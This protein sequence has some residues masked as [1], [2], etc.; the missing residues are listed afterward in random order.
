MSEYLTTMEAAEKLKMSASTLSKLRSAGTG[1]PYTKLNSTVR[2]RVE[3]LDAWAA[4]NLV[5]PPDGGGKGRFGRK[6][7]TGKR[8]EG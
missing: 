8:K 6:R 1:P 4:G 7:G 3:D 5:T 2:Y